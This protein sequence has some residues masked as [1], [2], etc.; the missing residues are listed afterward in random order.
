M[1]KISQPKWFKDGKVLIINA[2]TCGINKDG[3]T[4]FQVDEKN[5]KT[6]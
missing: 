2:P 4:Q 1:N 6:L 3:N 5:R